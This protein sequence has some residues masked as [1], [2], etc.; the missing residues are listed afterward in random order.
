MEGGEGSA[1]REVLRHKYMEKI[2]ICDIDQEVVDFYKKHLTQIVR[3]FVTRSLT[4][5]LTMPSPAE[6][7]QRQEKFDIIVGDLADPVERGPC[8]QLYTQSFYENIV[9]PKLDDTGIFVTQ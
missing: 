4:W 9:K 3:L 6:L 1:T 8:Y 2:I 5:S 7:E